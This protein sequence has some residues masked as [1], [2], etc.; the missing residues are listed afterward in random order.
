MLD[1]SNKCFCIFGLRG[2]GKSVLMHYMATKLGPSCLIFDTLGEIEGDPSYD[3]FKPFNRY[4]PGELEVVI[5]WVM[6]GAGGRDYKMFCIDEANRF[7]PSKPH[8][9]PQA[10]ADLNDWQRHARI[11]TGYIARRPVQLHQDLIELA[12]YLFI[13]NLK[14]KADIGYLE[15]ISAGLG[16]AVFSLQ[17][18]Y[19]ACVDPNRN[20]T[21]YPPIPFSKTT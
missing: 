7:C 12:E 14:G 11:T 18:W 9:L 13:F 17:P 3:V 1:L 19:F 21:L 20:Y 2:T 10:V 16:E 4:D 15:S 8:P 6:A 5:R